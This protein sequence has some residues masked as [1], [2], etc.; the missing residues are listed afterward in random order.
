MNEVLKAIMD[1]RSTRGFT[2][3][4]LTAA[5]TQSLVDAALASPT[6]CNYQDWHFCF[7]TDRALLKEYSDEYRG[8]L[9]EQCDAARREKYRE[10]DVFFNAPLVIFITLPDDARSNFAQ[11]DAGI[12]V[13]NLALAA[14][15]MGMGSVILGRPKEVLTGASGSR[16][17]ERLGFP[18]GHHF[19]IAIAIGHNTVTKDAHPVGEN[20][21]SFVG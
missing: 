5:E 18:Q 9:L 20:K 11:V 19:A 3:E 21:I 12:A 7:V 10:Y 1:R 4:A 2:D 16:W 6:A 15:G 17:E 8:I 14:H 13:E